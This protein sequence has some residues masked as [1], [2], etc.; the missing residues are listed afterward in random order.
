[1]CLDGFDGLQVSA[2]STGLAAMGC[3]VQ[4]VGQRKGPA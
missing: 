4:F 1:M 3:V 2:L